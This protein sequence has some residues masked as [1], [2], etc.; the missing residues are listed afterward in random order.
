MKKKIIIALATILGLIIGIFI[1]YNTAGTI[2]WLVFGDGGNL[3]LIRI[4]SYI[5]ILVSILCFGFSF[6]TIT[7]SLLN[8]NVTKEK[9]GLTGIIENNLLA[10]VFHL[11][12][13]FIALSLSGPIALIVGLLMYIGL[14]YFCKKQGSIMKN[15]ISFTSI[16]LLGLILWVAWFFSSLSQMSMTFG[17]ISNYIPFLYLS[18]FLFLG[19]IGLPKWLFAILNLIPPFLMWVGLNSKQKSKKRTPSRVR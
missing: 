10:I 17:N 8:Q 12:I 15:L 14:G 13:S 11:A 6:F 2:L 5:L 9:I 7:N 1:G 4:W 3:E 18:T 19:Q 16:P